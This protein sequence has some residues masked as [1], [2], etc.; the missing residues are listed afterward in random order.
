MPKR[1]VTIFTSSGWET[2]LGIFLLVL[3]L[4]PVLGKDSRYIVR[5]QLIVKRVVHLD[6]R[7]PAAGP[8]AFHFFE[9]EHRVR[10]NSLVLDAQF[11]LKPFVQLVSAA[12]HATDVRANLNIEFA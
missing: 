7:R 4:R 1:F 11:L 9:R 6:R 3:D 10:C 12:Q 5:L 8:D 2:S